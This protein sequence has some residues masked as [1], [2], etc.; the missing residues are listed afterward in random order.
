MTMSFSARFK[1]E[2]T[3]LMRPFGGKYPAMSPEIDRSM[4]NFPAP[5]ASAAEAGP[6]P[7]LDSSSNPSRAILD[8][9]FD[10]TM[11]AK[12][13]TDSHLTH[14]KSVVRTLFDMT[15]DKNCSHDRLHR[16]RSFTIGGKSWTREK[17]QV[18]VKSRRQP[19][20][21]WGIFFLR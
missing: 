7:T 6:M 17:R 8:I 10:S 5:V 3:D 20:F 11:F 14:K 2:N 15:Q 19:I 13:D 21:S 1:R 16:I 12:I 18:L 4:A 9:D